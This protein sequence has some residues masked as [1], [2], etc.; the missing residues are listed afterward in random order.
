MSIVRMRKVFQK[1]TKAKIGKRHLN[2]PSLAEGIFYLIILIFVAGA[3]YTFGGPATRGRSEQN[4]GGRTT[5]VVATVNGEKISRALFDLN[6]ASRQDLGDRDA[7]QERWTKA[8]LLNSLIDAALMRQATKR[9]HIKVTSADIRKKIDDE[10]EQTL[11]TRYSDKR[12]LK[13]HLKKENLTLDEFKAQL[14]R[15]LSQD[16]DRI[17]QQVAEDKLK[18]TVEQRVTLSDDEL[19]DSY[20]EVKASHILIKPD[21]EV[22]KAKPAAGQPRPD[23]DALAKQK[24]EALLA[25]VKQGAD[26]AKLARENSQD[27]GSAAKGGDLGYFKRGMMVKEFDEVA[28]KLQPGQVSDVFKSPFG[29]HFLKVTDRRATLPKD[30]EKNKATYREQV[31]SERKYRAWGEYQDN[32]KKQAQIVI[33]DPE[34]K[35]YSL[36]QDAERSGAPDRA[37]QGE[38]AKLLELAVKND[39]QNATALWELAG[40]LEQAGDK[41]RAAETLDAAVQTEIGAR[42][43]AMHMKLGDLYLELAKQDAAKKADLTQKAVD[44][45]KDTFDR[46]SAFT[47]MNYFTIMQLE[48]KVKPLSQPDLLKQI[49]QWLADFRAEQ[50][51][52]PTGGM[53]GFGPMGGMPFSIPPQ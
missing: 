36:L 14:R 31:L 7:T 4:Q 9:E 32:L 5:A 51:K 2:L 27:P 21:E 17:R 49:G 28:F 22:A 35:A 20:T 43:P 39:P 11:N 15:D 6:M 40:L 38:A 52:N 23:G 44:Q 37:K 24:A 18:E 42:S 41:A 34:L 30:F 46:A 29:Y 12:A 1:R 16:T 3:Y 13:R 47:Q 19:K 53:G 45:Y 8:G 10:V 25:Q 50:A 48:T 26:F 33:N